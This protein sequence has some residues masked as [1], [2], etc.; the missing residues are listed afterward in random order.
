MKIFKFQNGICKGPKNHDIWLMSSCLQSSPW[1]LRL[2]IQNLHIAMATCMI[3]DRR[4]CALWPTHQDQVELGVSWD[5]KQVVCILSDRY[6]LPSW[7]KF[8]VYLHLSH[9][10]YFATSAYLKSYLNLKF[11]CQ[12][13]VLVLSSYLSNRASTSSVATCSFPW[14]NSCSSPSIKAENVKGPSLSIWIFKDLL[15]TMKKV[16]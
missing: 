12:K 5:R 16:K 10:V 13:F 11:C 9:F 14:L 8:L 7:I 15:L 1:L 2:S 6:V 3:M 4:C